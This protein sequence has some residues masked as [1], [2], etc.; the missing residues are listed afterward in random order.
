MMKTAIFLLPGL[1][2][3][4]RLSAQTLPL[5]EED[6]RWTVEYADPVT[7][8]PESYQLHYQYQG[9]TLIGA[10]TYRRFG[11]GT[12]L[13]EV[14][15]TGKVY[16][17][18]DS[19]ECLLYDFDVAA[20][21]TLQLCEDLEVRIDS[22]GSV[23]TNDLIERRKYFVSSDNAIHLEYYLEGIGTNLGFVEWSEPIGPPFL[24]LMC[25]MEG[26]LEI[27]GDRCDEVVTS[28][29]ELPGVGGSVRFYPNPTW[30]PLTVDSELPY[31]N[32]L[33]Y[34]LSGRLVF[35]AEFR[36]EEYRIDRLAPGIYFACLRDQQGKNLR[37]ARI[38][39]VP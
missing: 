20:G 21:D 2:W 16:R 11:Y 36:K 39:K 23:T 32:L 27:Y 26:E 17:L 1:L 28:L 15:A 37:W 12:L 4:G 35:E 22:I 31:S 6:R 18:L 29:T 10:T 19:G 7:L 13:R 24:S 3:L 14:P 5:L 8:P 38:A 34:N 25:V 9:D 33:V 30:G